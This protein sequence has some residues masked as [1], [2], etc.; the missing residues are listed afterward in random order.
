[1]PNTG[2]VPLPTQSYYRALFERIADDTPEAHVAVRRACVWML[3]NVSMHILDAVA[4]ELKTTYHSCT[5][6]HQMGHWIQDESYR[7]LWELLIEPDATILEANIDGLINRLGH[8][9]PRLPRSFPRAHTPHRSFEHNSD[10]KKLSKE[11]LRISQGWNK[12][13]GI[14]LGK[15]KP[16]EAACVKLPWNCDLRIVDAAIMTLSRERSTSVVGNTFRD[17]V[18]ELLWYNI[19]TDEYQ[20]KTRNHVIHY[21]KTN[22]MHKD[23]WSQLSEISKMK[24][25]PIY[26]GSDNMFYGNWPPK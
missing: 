11:I 20:S 25:E 8:F 4:D 22:G 7:A 6:L 13:I 15:Y 9:H 16:L 17:Q 12:N 5:H 1:M 19:I 23:V 24:D 10:A 3:K 2:K 14:D 21:R 26:I 18:Y